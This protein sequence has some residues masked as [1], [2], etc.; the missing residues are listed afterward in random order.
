MDGW[1]G[2]IAVIGLTV[3]TVVTRGFFFISEREVPIPNWMPKPSG[4]WNLLQNGN[5]PEW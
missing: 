3:I 5:V 2:F 1:E 4:Y